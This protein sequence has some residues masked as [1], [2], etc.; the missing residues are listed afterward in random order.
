[1]PRRTPSPPSGPEWLHEPKLDGWRVQVHFDGDTVS[2]MSRRGRNIVERLPETKKA[3]R[4]L[5]V[6]SCVIDGELVGPGDVFALHRALGDRREDVIS[7]AAFDLLALNGIDL[8]TLPLSGRKQSLKKIV[9]TGPGCLQLVEDFPNGKELLKAGEELGLEGIVSKLRDKPYRSGTRGDW[10]KIKSP[11]WL[12]A[13][14]NRW[15]IFAR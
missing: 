1:V 7:I 11:A 5:R 6:K 14:R 12:E 3:L 9:D 8:R 10:L 13:N 2:I 15:E 4:S